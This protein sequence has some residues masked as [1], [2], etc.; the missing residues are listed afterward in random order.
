MAKIKVAY[1]QPNGFFSGA[2]ISLF[3][4]LNKIDRTK[5]EPFVIICSE[6][7]L[8]DY[9]ESI[10]VKVYCAV[11]KTFTST[12]TPNIFDSNYFYNIWALFAKNNIKQVLDLI[13]PDIVHVNDKSALMAGK[14]A[15]KLGYKVIWHLRSTYHQPKSFLQ[16]FISKKI[17]EK[18][19]TY[20]ISISEDEVDCFKGKNNLEIIYNSIDFDEI[21]KLEK[22]GSTFRNEFKVASDEIGVGMFGNLDSQ[23]GAWNFIKAAGYIKKSRPD[24]KIKYFLIAPIPKNI[25]YGWR[26]KLGLIDTT[27]AYEKA[28]SLVKDCEIENCT[29]FTDRRDDILNIMMGLDIVSA[30]Y[31]LNA[32]G[33]PAIEAASVG[34]PVIVNR[35]NTNKS[36]LIKPEI[37]GIV[38]E[39]ENYLE[40]GNSIIMLADNKERMIEM[41]LLGKE[42]ARS[43]FDSKINC[44]KIENIYSALVKS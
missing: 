7:P 12:P 37:T 24:L 38:I 16:Y 30:V 2:A 39:K 36:S 3:H 22:N 35:G 10:G 19:A 34:K 44:I 5:F 32:I 28:I 27:S 23:K 15:F 14:H 25:N 4:I 18:N 41:G 21:E 43:C 31:N 13:K 9:Y 6:G 11:Y 1:I 42:Y 8:R 29:F 26:G 40:L 17:I 20:F 33:R